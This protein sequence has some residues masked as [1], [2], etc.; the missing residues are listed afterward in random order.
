M[1]TG[2][3][4]TDSDERKMAELRRILRRLEPAELGP[5]VASAD[6]PAAPKYVRFGGLSDPE[7]PPP[8]P[9][10][11]PLPP[12]WPSELNSVEPEAP[13]AP[14]KNWG[15]RPRL[16]A[17]GTIAAI[18]IVGLILRIDL[19]RPAAPA[20]TSSHGEEKGRNDARSG[21]IATAS[22]APA[23]KAA[24][25]EL[26]VRSFAPPSADGPS[27]KPIAPS[28]SP[29]ASEPAPA[30]VTQPP[31]KSPEPIQ[32]ER[33]TATIEPAASA[34]LPKP[35]MSSTSVLAIPPSFIIEAGV[36]SRFPLR[37]AHDAGAVDGGYLIVSGL[38]RGSRFSSGTEIVFDTWQIP[39]D[40]LG[41]LQLTIPSDGETELAIELRSA[42]GQTVARTTAVLQGVMPASAPQRR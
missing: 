35:G 22:V 32:A 41:G 36:A 19:P 12:R 4:N 24:F 38:L 8:L 39:V 28:P 34:S 16:A 9:A 3:Q 2:D 33:R 23:E 6:E 17:A 25:D 11:P 15:L 7:Q 18:A 30:A 40:A 26:A 14:P 10:F 1:D 13:A 27:A 21:S 20:S 42:Q 31:P 29:E 5:A 37:L